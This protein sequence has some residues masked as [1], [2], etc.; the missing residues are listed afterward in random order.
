MD[1]SF[2]LAERW[3]VAGA[4]AG[5]GGSAEFRTDVFDAATIETM[6][7][8][9][10]RVLGLMVGDATWR[11][12]SVDVLDEVEQARLDGF[13]NRVVLDTPAAAVSV[14]EVFAGWCV[15]FRR[16]WRSRSGRCR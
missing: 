12:S 13:G 3:S 14:P 8:R 1:L 2:S 7:E 16:R 10:R 5:I 4:P 15:A 11:L 6:L 9:L